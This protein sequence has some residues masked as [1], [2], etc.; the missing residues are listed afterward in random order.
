MAKKLP[1]GRQFVA[2]RH[3]FQADRIPEFDS[4][5]AGYS[6]LRNQMANLREHRFANKTS[7]SH[8]EESSTRPMVMLISRTKPSDNRASVQNRW[9]HRPKSSMW[10]LFVERSVCIPFPIPQNTAPN[11][12]IEGPVYGSSRSNGTGVRIVNRA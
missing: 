3:R 9:L 8:F 10:A 11:P 1:N 2:Q 12:P 5:G 4:A 6:F 7:R